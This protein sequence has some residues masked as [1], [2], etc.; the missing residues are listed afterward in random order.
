MRIDH[1][2]DIPSGAN[3]SKDTVYIDKSI[4]QYSPRLK[5]KNGRPA[6]LW[7]YLTIHETT[8]ARAMARGL[9][10]LKA[11]ETVA[12]PAERKAVEADG[13]NWNAYTR[14]MDGYLSHTE[15]KTA[16]PPPGLHIS[17]QQADGHHRS[18]NKK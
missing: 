11:H 3:S 8:E 14:E 9:P 1:S 10:Y 2:R 16:K 13:V 15:R 5:D 12:T 4:P 18:P 6:N 7:K 17:P